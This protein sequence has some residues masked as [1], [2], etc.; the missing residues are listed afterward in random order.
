NQVTDLGKL[1]DPLADKIF[2]SAIMLMMVEF[3]MMPAWIAVIVISREFMVTGLR[4]LA[5]QTN[6][7]IPADG[8]GKVKTVMQMA[9]LFIGGASWV[10]IFSL[11]ADVLVFGGTAWLDILSASFSD[12]FRVVDGALQMRCWFL[13]K[14]FLWSMTAVTIYSGVG[15][16]IK[17]KHLFSKK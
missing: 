15:Y 16:F 7:V 11:R 3:H 8:W 1:I 6:V 10:G 12:N 14:L 13:W 5:L 17:F 9:I 2:V 4:M